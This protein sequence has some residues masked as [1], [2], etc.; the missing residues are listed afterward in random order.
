MRMAEKARRIV[1]LAIIVAGLL[2]AVVGI[3]NAQ[4]GMSSTPEKTDSA[5]APNRRAGLQEHQGA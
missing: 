1:F 5:S 4:S 2:A 3:I